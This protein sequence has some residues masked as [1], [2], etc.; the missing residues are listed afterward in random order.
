MNM[1]ERFVWR[2]PDR[3]FVEGHSLDDLIAVINKSDYYI[4]PSVTRMREVLATKNVFEY[5]CG[6]FS[7]T[8]ETV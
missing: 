1:P 7:I 8:R 6:I 2:G 3:I 5:A 4:K